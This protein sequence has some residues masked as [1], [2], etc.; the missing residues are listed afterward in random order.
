MHHAAP[1]SLIS[2]GLVALLV[3]GP[4]L[5]GTPEHAAAASGLPPPN[6]KTTLVS[7]NVDLDFPSG[8]SVEASISENGG[9]VAFSSL[10][11]D[12]VPN[13]NNESQDVFIVDRRNGHPDRL[14]LPGGDSVPK[15]GRA[16][17]PSI[18]ADASTV[19]FTY[20]PPQA[21][22][23]GVPPGPIVLVWD[24]DS[25]T[26][27]IAS[28]RLDGVAA[29]NSREPSVS[30]DG[31]LVAYTSDNSR[32]VNPDQNETADAFVFDRDTGNT[33]LVSA[34]LD[35]QP[36]GGSSGRPSISAN[37]RFVGFDSNAVDIV[38]LSGG[39]EDFNVYL[40]DLDNETTELIS[41]D[42]DGGY[43]NGGS[44]AASVSS[45]GNVVA[46][47]S[48]ATDLFEG[49]TATQH[50]Y[51]RDRDAG[52]TDLASVGPTGAPASGPSG[53]ASIAADGRIVAFI[54]SA[55][56]LL[57]AVDSPIEL[58][59]VVPP[60]SEVYAR[61]LVAGDTILISEA[62]GGGPAG[63]SNVGPSVG[64]NGRYVAFASNSP[65]LVQGDD[66]QQADVFLRDLPGDPGIVPPEL[67]FGASALGVPAIPVGAIVSN[68]G[69]APVRL[70]A[71]TVTGNH[72]SDFTILA[73]GCA[74]KRLR[75]AQACTISVGFT[76]SAKGNRTARLNVPGGFGGSP[77]TAR[78]RGGGSQAVLEL[79]PPIGNPG[80]VTVVSGRGFPEGAR[81][82]LNWSKGITPHLP[83][84][85]VDEDGRFRIQVLVFHHDRIGERELIATHAGGPLFADVKAKMNVTAS[86]DIPTTWDWQ[87]QPPFTPPLIQRR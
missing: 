32:I 17:D 75:R 20:L 9:W 33:E 68:R 84:I 64:G 47:E 60:Q 24:R 15:G 50:I 34:N 35:G 58:A 67:V 82:E 7:K 29:N 73:D 53:Q 72:A 40:R 12:L 36:P 26:T 38:E 46:F 59:A 6:G 74:D 69:W 11:A 3:A 81:V 42:L 14:P 2:V 87:H 13:D 83:E 51:V 80:I 77:L 5:F 16:F 39:T 21:N 61:E 85:V 30:G 71:A 25:D 27:T 22:L 4:A 65:Q 57:A 41:V 44:Q 10:A 86:Q 31:R 76:P 78:L 1:R 66:N 79:D 54:S 37:G 8:P 19:A 43:G 28:L 70:E 63:G 48:V 52:S 49:V 23:T 56:D 18:S 55:D 45:N 62:R